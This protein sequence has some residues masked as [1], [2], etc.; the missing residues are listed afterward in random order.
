MNG[1]AV[2]AGALAAPV[3]VSYLVEA[4]RS[5]P[6]APVRLPW[7][8]DLPVRYLDLDG[9]RIRYVAAGDGPALVLLH[10]LRT[11]LDMFQRVI[12]ELA[13]RFRVYA[14]DYPGHGYSDIPRA[15]YTAEYF[16][17]AV[18]RF[19]DAIGVEDAMLVGESIGANIALVLAA[20]RHPRVARVIAINPYDYAAGRGLRR[21]SAVANV[22]LGLAP[23]PVLGATL[24]RFRHPILER[25]IFEGGVRRPASLP[26][27][28]ASEMSAV[29]N[30]PGHYRAFLSLVRH[31]PSWEAVRSEYGTIDRPVLLVYGEH[32]W[33]NAAE[34]EANRRAI[35][36]N[37]SLTVR[38]AGHFLSLE[39]PDELTRAVTAFASGGGGV[40]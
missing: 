32:D 40:M 34:R 24:L 13:K 29:G 38:D 19:L 2:L 28:L 17:A 15:D 35:P 12:P 3:L 6:P 26:A 30:R 18:A 20:R 1:I 14:L 16:I 10:T 23:V 39:A 21:G 11:Q 9:V 31:W 5:A 8:P 33:S 36:G 4:V 27:E 37:R 7:A 22:L 25:K